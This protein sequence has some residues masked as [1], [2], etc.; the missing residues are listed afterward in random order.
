MT[1]NVVRTRAHAFDFAGKTW[2]KMVITAAP[3]M[4]SNGRVQIAEIDIHDISATASGLPED[5]WFF[6]GDSITAFAF[7]RAALHKAELRRRDQ[8]RDRERVHAGDDQ[9]R[10]RR[11][12]V[13]RRPGAP[14]PTRWR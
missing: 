12:K 11:R 2:I 1:G 6:M 3:P 10:H 9:R 14:A 13:D 7:D 4:A 5:T 8:H